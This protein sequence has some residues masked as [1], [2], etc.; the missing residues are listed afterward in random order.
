MDMNNTILELREYG[1][2]Y[3]GKVIIKSIDL[4]IPDR[5]VFMIMG[6]GG[7]G[8]STLLRTLSCYNN[9]NP[10]MTVWGEAS[11]LGLPVSEQNRPEMVIQ[12]ARL[13][14]ATI[15]DNIV[16][17]L[18]ERQS[19]T[20]QEQ[21]A[22]VKRLLEQGGLGE[23]SDKLDT[24]VLD[25]SLAQ[26]RH[27]SILRMICNEPRILFVDEPTFEI[28]DE[29][30]I[31]LLDYMRA[32]AEKRAMV[33][34]THNQQH[35]KYLGGITALI[36]GGVVQKVKPTTVFFSSPDDELTQTFVRTG[37][38]SV[39]APQMEEV[40]EELPEDD[41]A[42]SLPSAEARFKSHSYGPNGFL[43]LINGKLAGTPR[44]G[45]VNELEYDLEAL[46]RVGVTHLLTLT[47]TNPDGQFYEDA[48]IG[49][50]WYP[51]DDM[52]A[53][54]LSEAGALCEK[55]DRLIKDGEVVAVHCKA[56]LGRTGTVLAAYLIWCGYAA[57]DALE[58]VRYINPRWVQSETQIQFLETFAGLCARS[59][60]LEKTG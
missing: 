26:Q 25:L 59:E 54:D 45:I 23:L 3:H 58:K 10:N 52:H 14:M 33:I 37:S 39:P 18:P 5:G 8:K 41:R 44:P 13:L 48:G 12:K 40:S 36:A 47:E 30:A 15:F 55:I 24:S 2:A 56:G 29:E 38:V 50:S 42:H 22:L 43:W 49:N 11:Y 51:I 53:P 28:T 7:T 16:S 34:T 60:S 35:A 46:Q 27:I 17:Y 6:P 9:N 20:R 57:V 1:I 21:R 31:P 4:A 19:L 32:E